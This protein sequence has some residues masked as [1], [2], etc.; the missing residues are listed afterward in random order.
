MNLLGKGESHPGGRADEERPCVFKSLSDKDLG[1]H[2]LLRRYLMKCRKLRKRQIPANPFTSY[3]FFKTSL[4]HPISW[5]LPPSTL[6]PGDGVRAFCVHLPSS[7][8]LFP[9]I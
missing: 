6:C 7:A 2:L 5:K 1:E 3:L 8:Y 4:M 9:N